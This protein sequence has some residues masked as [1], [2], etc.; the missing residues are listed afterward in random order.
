MKEDDTSVKSPKAGQD[1]EEFATATEVSETSGQTPLRK[2]GIINS[3]EQQMNRKRSRTW[4]SLHV[5]ISVESRV[6]CHVLGCSGKHSSCIDQ[7]PFCGKE[8]LQWH[9]KPSRP[10]CPTAAV[11]HHDS[12][13]F[14]GIKM[15]FQL[16]S[17][18]HSL[19]LHRTI[20]EG[21]GTKIC[22][23]PAQQMQKKVAMDESIEICMG[24]WTC[25][26]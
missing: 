22:S 19:R 16:V 24:H 26:N 25:T 2:R 10:L 14:A 18:V 13:C 3:P 9:S 20:V 4:G 5:Q 15:G 12:P 6:W 21:L 23:F 1:H 8:R 7:K 17:L 11:H